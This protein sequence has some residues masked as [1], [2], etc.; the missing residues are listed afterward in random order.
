MKFNSNNDFIPLFIFIL[1]S[2]IPSNME[3]SGECVKG[4]GAYLSPFSLFDYNGHCVN[5][6]EERYIRSAL[7]M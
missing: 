6:A 5:M 2:Q 4:G 7:T 1:S 3:L